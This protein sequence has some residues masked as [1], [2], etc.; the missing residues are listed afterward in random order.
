MFGIS[1]L[2]TDLLGPD[3]DGHKYFDDNVTEAKNVTRALL[4]QF[5]QHA[6]DRFNATNFANYQISGKTGYYKIP[7]QAGDSVSYAVTFN[8]NGN[9]TSD[10]NTGTTHE[11]K[12]QD[13]QEYVVEAD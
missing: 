4:M 12:E 13:N 8:P 5:L 11:A 7:F 9:Q 3:A 1:G 10:V 6:P 2:D